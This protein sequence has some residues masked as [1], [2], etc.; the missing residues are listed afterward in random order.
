[1]KIFYI[2]TALLT[3]GGADR[4]ITEK[5]NWLAEHG[6]DVAVVTDTQLG[7]EPIFPLSSKVRLID[8]AV[9]FSK[10][11]GHHFIVRTFLYYKL[12]YQ[13]RKKI[14]LFLDDIYE[15]ITDKN[16]TEETI[17]SGFGMMG[18]R[19]MNSL[20]D[21]DVPLIIELES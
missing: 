2:Y 16:W 19:I 13:Y 8:V 14:D 11:Y 3:K 4:V 9:D 18:Y 12:M 17:F 1:M 7:R 21:T 10:E 20:R 6:H 5:A 15:Q